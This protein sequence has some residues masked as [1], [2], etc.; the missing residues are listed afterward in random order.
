MTD[1]LSGVGAWAFGGCS[2]L[3]SVT[4]PA[5][6]TSLSDDAFHYAT[7]LTG[8]IFEGAAPVMGAAVFDNTAAGFTIYYA[9]GATGFTSPTWTGAIPASASAWS[10]DSMNRNE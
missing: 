1:S 10:T 9:S 8:A 3:V 5:S 7:S 2:G 6:V 4:L